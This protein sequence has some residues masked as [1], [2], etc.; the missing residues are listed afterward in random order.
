MFL[1]F[2]WLQTNVEIG[3]YI[4]KWKKLTWEFLIIYNCLIHLWQ[5]CL[6]EFMGD[7]RYKFNVKVYIFHYYYQ[8]FCNNIA[9]QIG[10]KTSWD[11]APPLFTW[12]KEKHIFCQCKKKMF[13]INF[14]KHFW[15][16]FHYKILL[17]T[18][19]SSRMRHGC[20]TYNLRQMVSL[21]CELEG[22]NYAKAIVRIIILKK[23]ARFHGIIHALLRW[24]KSNNLSSYY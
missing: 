11:V 14:K 7:K 1:V 15:S 12:D 22:E 18:I 5:T 19:L 24:I 2:R 21:N 9:I 6:R 8:S 16:S 10:E 20:S 3:N 23:N 4:N 13:W 17:T